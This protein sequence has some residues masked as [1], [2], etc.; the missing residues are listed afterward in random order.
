MKKGILIIFLLAAILSTVSAKAKK[1]IAKPCNG[2]TYIS[3]HRTACFGRCP[4]YMIELYSNGNVKYSGYMFVPDSGVYQKNIGQAKV[5]K[6]FK[7][8]EL[9]RVDTCREKYDM[10]M[11]DLPGLYY[12]FIYKGKSHEIFNANF[13]PDFL[14][15]LAKEIDEAIKPDA[16]WKK[17]ASEAKM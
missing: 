2:I 6:I 17:L 9:Y 16:S 5:L 3:M 11:Q 8:F 10:R 13:G 15:D 12:S 14:T 4:D 7:D 1:K